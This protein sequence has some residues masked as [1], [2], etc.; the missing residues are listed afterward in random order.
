MNFSFNYGLISYIFQVDEWVEA[1]MW[2]VIPAMIVVIVAAYLLGEEVCPQHIKIRD[3]LEK[4][5]ALFGQQK[6]D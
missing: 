1:P 2:A 4:A 5:A 3:E 6:E